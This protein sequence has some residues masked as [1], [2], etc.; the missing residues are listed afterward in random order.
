MVIR[1]DDF[2]IILHV[3]FVYLRIKYYKIN[4]DIFLLGHD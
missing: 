4:I 3:I 1:H 2:N